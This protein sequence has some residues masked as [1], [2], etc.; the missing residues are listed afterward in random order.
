MPT[1]RANDLDI[2]YEVRGAGPPLI[3]VHGAATTAG[4]TFGKQ[5]P[6]LT[7]AFQVFLPDARGHGATRW[8]LGGGFRAAWLVEDLAGFVDALGLRTFHLVGYSM[9]A[10]TAL[11]YAS[12]HP[13]RL[14][15]LVVAGITTAREPRASVVRRLMDPGRIVRDE[16]A[17]ADDL[18][19][20]DET[21]GAGHWRALVTA[22]AADVASQPLLTPSEIRA[23]TAPTLVMCGNRDP[24]VPV[25]QAAALARAVRDGRLFVAPRAGHDLTNEQ[26]ELCATALAGFYRSTEE[27]ARARAGAIDDATEVPR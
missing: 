3:I 26:P 10:M 24:L 11:G 8:D 4:Y 5:L 17:W 7:G 2:G 22:V 12:R 6:G 18:D 23:I 20:L 9:G 1:I 27:I 21:H 19:R 15:T 13:E 14:R 16:P 25:A